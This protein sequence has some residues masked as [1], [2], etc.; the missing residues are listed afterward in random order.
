V[1]VHNFIPSTGQQRQVDHCEFEVGMVYRVSSRTAKATQRNPVL[2]K[3]T[4]QQQE[5]DKM[6]WKL[7]ACVAIAERT[8]VQFPAPVNDLKTVHKL[9]LQG[10]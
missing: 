7:K 8:Q 1:V 6:G 2:K 9:E 3:Q 5:V 10:I 4:K